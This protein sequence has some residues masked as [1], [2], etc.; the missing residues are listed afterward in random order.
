MWSENPDLALKIMFHLGSSQGRKKDR[1]GF[2]CCMDWLWHNHPITLLANLP[3]IPKLNYF[4][5]LAEVL[6]RIT[7]NDEILRY[8]RIKMHTRSYDPHSYRQRMMKR[9]G[10]GQSEY[11]NYSNR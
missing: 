11:T 1:Q 5:G 10:S 7:E 9:R 6:D 2:Y 8:K 4:K 3:H